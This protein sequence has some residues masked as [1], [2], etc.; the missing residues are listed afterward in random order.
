VN[1]LKHAEGMDPFDYGTSFNP[2]AHESRTSG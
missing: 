1:A 2:F